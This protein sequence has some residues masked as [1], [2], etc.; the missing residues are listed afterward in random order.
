MIEHI[1]IYIE[2]IR[3]II[4]KPC[5][6]TFS[7]AVISKCLRIRAQVGVKKAE[8]PEEESW[9]KARCKHMFLFLLLFV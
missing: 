1:Y 9:M 6:H 7:L 4:W 2:N 5:T 8:L 3:R